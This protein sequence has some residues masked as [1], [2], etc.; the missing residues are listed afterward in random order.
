VSGDA[1]ANVAVLADPQQNLKLVVH[2]GRVILN[3][4]ARS[5][6]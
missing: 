2:D 3:E 6:P 5:S 1:V 4:I